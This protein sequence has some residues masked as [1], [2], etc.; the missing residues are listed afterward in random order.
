MR[1]FLNSRS[2]RGTLSD[3]Q[4]TQATP[5]S[6][7]SLREANRARVVSAVQQHG[8][9]T[10]VELAGITGLSRASVSNIVTELAELGVLDTSPSIRSGRRAR[11]VTIARTVGL[12]GGI[13][14]GSRTMR[15]A[16]SDASLQIVA[17][18]VLPLASDHRADLSLQRAAM[19]VGEMVESVGGSGDELLA[20]GVGV[21]APVDVAHGRVSSTGL[22]RGWD[23]AAVTDQLSAALHVPVAVDNNSNLGALAEARFGAAVGCDPVA[24]VR[25]SG[26]VG[27]GLVLNGQVLHGRRGTA[28]ELGHVVID[29]HGAVCRCGNRGCLETVVGAAGLLHMLRASHGNVTLEDVIAR[30]LQGDVGCQRAIADTGRTLGAAIANLCNLFDPEMVVI[31]GRLAEAGEI[32]LEPLRGAVDQ[33]TLRSTLGSPAVVAAEFGA[34]AELRGALAAALDRARELGRLGVPA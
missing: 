24:Y 30:A 14:V 19:L 3:V 11:L 7:T 12:V 34:E 31:G 18:E 17:T 6:Q 25:L 23:G 8:S 28:G 20:I 4:Q 2:A 26:T 32:L 29:P 5:G 27:A 21:P 9:L 22:L 33:H 16:L 10:Q 15:V 1:Y 13:D